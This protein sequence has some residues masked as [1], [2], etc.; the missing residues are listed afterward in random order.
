[1]IVGPWN[2]HQQ[3][4][5]GNRSPTNLIDSLLSATVAHDLLVNAKVTV[6]ALGACISKSAYLISGFLGFFEFF[7]FPKT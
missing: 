5:R 6:Y 3:P 1:M 2:S 4:C 7:E